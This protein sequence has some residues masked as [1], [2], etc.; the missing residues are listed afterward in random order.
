M[1]WRHPG[2]SVI[3]HNSKM[4]ASKPEIRN[5]TILNLSHCIFASM[6]AIATKFQYLQVQ[7]FLS[8][9]IQWYYRNHHAK[10]PEGENPRWRHLTK[11]IYI[12]ACR[13]DSYE[14]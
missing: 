2:K 6:L 14:I 5:Y 1:Q 7:M 8:T 3:I 13:C 11:I 12:S 4:V 9:T 10:K